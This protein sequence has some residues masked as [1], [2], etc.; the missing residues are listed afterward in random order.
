MTL[1]LTP[2][3]SS[4]GDYEELTS[5][6]ADAISTRTW[7]DDVASGGLRD[8]LMSFNKALREP[9][10]P[11]RGFYLRSPSTKSTAADLVG[12]FHGEMPIGNLVVRM[13]ADI[14]ARQIRLGDTIEGWHETPLLVS[15]S[16][17]PAIAASDP[18]STIE[19]LST[20]VG[21]PVAD[22]L[23]AAS[24]SRSTYYAWKSPD[25]PRPRL[26]SMGRLWEMAQCVEDLEEVLGE[27]VHYWLLASTRRRRLFGSGQFAELLEMAQPS[28]RTRGL[29]PAHAQLAA[30]GGDRLESDGDQSIRRERRGQAVTVARMTAADRNHG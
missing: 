13:D 14:S 8:V 29:A 18:I 30:I 4:L 22:V 6:D 11:L 5:F 15:N 2:T 20:R 21:L 26:A 28:A 3:G 23:R 16:F 1:A 17:A 12:R 27:S 10:A 7:L 24:I 19:S 9:L 25:N